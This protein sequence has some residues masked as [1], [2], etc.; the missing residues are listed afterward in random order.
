MFKKSSVVMI[1]N[2]L[3]LAIFCTLTMA[4]EVENSYSTI[5]GRV[6]DIDYQMD[7]ITIATKTKRGDT[8]E[9]NIKISKGINY[10]FV[11]DINGL[12]SVDS[13]KE[14]KLGD[15]VSIKCKES[16]GEYETV[17]IEKIVKTKEIKFTEDVTSLAHQSK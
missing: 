12:L 13:F 10:I 8:N 3:F 4:L 6:K 1:I 16:K 14:L 11:R 9:L 2:L 7:M 5:I 15:D 17:E